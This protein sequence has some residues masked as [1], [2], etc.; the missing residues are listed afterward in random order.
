MK[1]KLNQTVYYS[2]LQHHTIP[3]R[4]QLVGQGFVLL[5]DNDP[6]HTGKLCQRSIKSKEEQHI[7][8]QISWSAQSADLNSIE[9]MQDELDAKVRAK[10]PTSAAHLWQLLQESW[11]ELFS[12]YLQSLGRRM[13]R[14]CEAVIAAKWMNPKVYE[15]F[16]FFKLYL[17][18]A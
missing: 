4:T 12:V 18:V 11:A 1:D 10:Q 7:L 3:C 8:Q 5:Q 9:H 2:L 16:C 13:L 6:K 14:I 17:I 15:V